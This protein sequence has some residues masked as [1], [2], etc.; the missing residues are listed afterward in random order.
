[1]IN[2][3]LELVKK[4]YEQKKTINPD[5]PPKQTFTGWKCPKC[6]NKLKKESVSHPIFFEEGGSDGF[7]NMVAKDHGV[8]F[9][10][11][12][13]TMEHLTCKCGYEFYHSKLDKADL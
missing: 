11:Y 7:V 8:P 6:G 5:V 3:E 9:G 4:L 1:M 13:M 10:L 12:N 2:K